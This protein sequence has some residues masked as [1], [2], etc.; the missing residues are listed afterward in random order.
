VGYNLLK[1]KANWAQVDQITTVISRS[2]GNN[3]KAHS[4]AE[5]HVRRKV[6]P[7][8]NDP[9]L[10]VHEST[11]DLHAQDLKEKRHYINKIIKKNLTT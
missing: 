7:R 9:T 5:K 11:M 2:N 1:T 6:D 4:K 8:S 10:R 3:T